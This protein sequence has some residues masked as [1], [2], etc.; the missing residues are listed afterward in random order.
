[1]MYCRPV[2]EMATTRMME[3]LDGQLCDF[4]Q[5]YRLPRAGDGALEGKAV[6]ALRDHLF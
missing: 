3:A 4:A 6:L 5:H 2:A 1:M